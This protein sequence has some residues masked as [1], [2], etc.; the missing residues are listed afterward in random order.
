MKTRFLHILLAVVLGSSSGIVAQTEDFSVELSDSGVERERYF[1]AITLA[2]NAYERGEYILAKAKAA[3]ARMYEPE[4][5]LTDVIEMRVAVAEMEYETAL[6]KA[7]DVLSK[8]ET[9]EEAWL[10]IYSL[11]KD[12]HEARIN[13]LIRKSCQDKERAGFW[14]CLVAGSYFSNGEYERA[15]KRFEQVMDSHYDYMPYAQ[16]EIIKCYDC[17]GHDEQV[18]KLADEYLAFVPDDSLVMCYRACANYEL[19][20]LDAAECDF[21]NIMDCFPSLGAEC[22]LSLGAISE[23][24]NDYVSAENYYTQ[25]I[26]LGGENVSLGY[27]YRGSLLKY[28]LGKPEQAVEA[29][30]KCIKSD[31]SGIVAPYAYAELGMEDEAIMFINLA[32]DGLEGYSVEKNYAL[33]CVYA[34]LANKSMALEYL[35][36]AIDEGVNS[37][38]ELKFN[39]AFDFMR[40]DS[41]FKSLVKKCEKAK[42]VQVVSKP[43]QMITYE[44]PLSLDPSG[45]YQVKACINGLPLDF[46]LDTGCSGVSMSQLEYDFM[47]KNGLI[48]EKDVKGVGCSINAE[49]EYHSHQNVMLKTVKIGDVEVRNVMVSVTPNDTAP[50]LLG[51][52]VLGRFGK[53]AIDHEKNSLFITV[54]KRQD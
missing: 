17:L 6:T 31:L 52:G 44:I 26:A 28:G 16:K 19:L 53:I 43:R 29:F 48:S 2:M 14:N 1:D 39:N 41:K 15:I 25:S 38:S 27:L 13:A 22:S 49:G 34:S 12:V 18:V 42:K 11:P 3:E 40:D 30:E 35:S 32:Y 8:D 50:L 10:T 51:M 5:L 36:A 9:F 20:K 21:K 37:L 54:P 23:L 46:M 4:M 33:A 45:V 47:V 7:I 24:K